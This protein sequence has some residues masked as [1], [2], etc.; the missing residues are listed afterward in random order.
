MQVLQRMTDGAH[1]GVNLEAALCC[2]K[3]EGA[4]R[5]VETPA[6]RRRGWRLGLLREGRSSQASGQQNGRRH[7][8]EHA[9]HAFSIGLAVAPDGI[10]P[11][12]PRTGRLMLSGNGKGRS[13][14]PSTGRITRKW[15]K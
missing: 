1:L 10:G 8:M 5:A 14:F 12:P 11:P 9:H 13:N 15:R 7:M 4:E 2:G 6:L 3:I